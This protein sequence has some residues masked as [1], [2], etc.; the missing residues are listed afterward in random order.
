MTLAVLMMLLAA[1][2]RVWGIIGSSLVPSI[3]SRDQ[4]RSFLSQLHRTTNR[5]LA[6]SSIES[7]QSRAAVQAS[8]YFALAFGFGVALIA[9]L[10]MREK[11]VG[12]QA[13][14]LFYSALLA[15]HVVT[16]FIGVLHP[17][18]VVWSIY[19]G[20]VLALLLC[21]PV[22]NRFNPAT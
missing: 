1:L 19:D 17:S 10:L 14:L 4:S 11:R 21:T 22:R 15:L 3:L 2:A 7:G 9:P 16:P 12:W 13:A 5:N 8:V 6:M 18:D 20:V